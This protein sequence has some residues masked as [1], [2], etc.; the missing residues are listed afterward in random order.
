MTA[1]TTLLEPSFHDLIA[2]I[3]Q[4]AEL[5]EQRRRHWVC[6]LRQTAKW[7]GRP[8]T[9]IPARWHSVRIAVGQL[10]QAR[11]GVT[12]KTLANHKSNVRAALRWFGSEHDMPQQGARLSSQ[13][14]R[15]RDGL[16]KPTRARLY[17]LIRYSST[18]GIAP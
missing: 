13:W 12:A 7:L 4:A 3:E 2:T 16:D 9:V 17:C 1:V 18:R 6:S 15:F 14:T 8:P 5:S 11:L 10:H